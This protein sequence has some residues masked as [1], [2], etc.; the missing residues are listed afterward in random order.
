MLWQKRVGAAKRH[1]AECS[2]ELLRLVAGSDHGL[3]RH[4]DV[5][6]AIRQACE[7]EKLTRNKYMRALRIYTHLVVY[8]T[9]PEERAS[10]ENQQPFC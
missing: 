9:M 3:F 2:R 7:R 8:G 6:E 4:L 10:K 5:R 1:Y